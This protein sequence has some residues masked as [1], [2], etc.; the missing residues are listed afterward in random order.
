[1]YQVAPET[2]YQV[3]PET[4]YQVA[5]ETMYQVAPET[6]YQVA[7]ERMYQVAPETMVAAG[8]CFTFLAIFC[9]LEVYCT[10]FFRLL[11]A[12]I[13]FKN[14]N[15]HSNSLARKRHPHTKA[16]VQPVTYIFSKVETVRWIIQFL[17]HLAGVVP[18]HTT[19]KFD[20]QPH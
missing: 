12:T 14:S 6:M 1:M 5:P 8:D 2:M 18:R 4:M 3:A 19:L 10:S 7:P 9:V 15:F 11:A 16:W 13:N 17:K 20:L